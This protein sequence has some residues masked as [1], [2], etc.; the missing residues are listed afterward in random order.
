MISSTSSN[1]IYIVPLNPPFEK[2]FLTYAPNVPYII[3]PEGNKASLHYTIL[4]GALKIGYIPSSL[5]M[6]A[7][8]LNST[9]Y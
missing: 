5:K 1:P 7:R 9:F 3:L 8:N 2:N 6:P 4:I